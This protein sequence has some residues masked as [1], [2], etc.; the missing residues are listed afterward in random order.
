MH[1]KN[2]DRPPTRTERVELDDGE[3]AFGV[4]STQCRKGDPLLKNTYITIIVKYKL[5]ILPLLT[6]AHT[7]TLGNSSLKVNLRAYPYI[8]HPGGQAYRIG[9]IALRFDGDRRASHV[10]RDYG[11]FRDC[12]EGF[13]EFLPIGVGQAF[14]DIGAFLF[15]EQHD[16]SLT[17]ESGFVHR[18]S[19]VAFFP[20]MRHGAGII[21]HYSFFLIDIL[22]IS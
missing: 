10:D 13:G 21:L 7:F 9:G 14:Q 11:N 8:R 19:S 18:G 16:P 4:K 17:G 3:Y 22:R 6:E 2:N 5:K 15:S 20:V 1:I 12:R